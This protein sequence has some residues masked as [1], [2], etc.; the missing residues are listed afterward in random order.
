MGNTGQKKMRTYTSYKDG[1]GEIHG[2]DLTL[3]EEGKYI[4]LSVSD[5]DRIELDDVLYLH[6]S[7]FAELCRMIKPLLIE[8][9]TDEV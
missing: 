3:T 6:P 7:E 9:S 1:F 4:K 8:V 2:Q 5:P